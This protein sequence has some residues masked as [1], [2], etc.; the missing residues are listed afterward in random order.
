MKRAKSSP[1]V[2]KAFEYVR[3]KLETKEWLAGQRLPPAR[4][5]AAGA[6][7]SFTSMI[8]AIQLLKAQGFITVIERGHIRAAGSGTSA[9]RTENP[10]AASLNSLKRAAL[11]QDIL[12]GVYA[13]Q[14]HLPTLKELTVRYGVHYRTIRKILL[15]MVADK[16]LQVHGKTFNFIRTPVRTQHQRI[17]F[18]THN[19]QRVPVTAL[20]R[21][22]YRMF[23]LL[24]HECS[25]RGIQLAIMDIEKFISM[26][27]NRSLPIDSQRDSETGFIVDTWWVMGREPESL[28]NDLLSRL[29]VLK[30]PVAIVD[31]FGWFALS[32]PFVMN[33]LFQVFC[34]ERR[35]AGCQVAR[36]LLSTGHRSIVF[37]SSFHDQ[38]WSQERLNGI[39]EQYAKAGCGNGVNRAVGR[40]AF[41]TRD[42]VLAISGFDESLIRKLLPRDTPISEDEQYRSFLELK[43]TFSPRQY[44]TDEINHIRKRLEIIK[45]VCKIEMSDRDFEQIFNV[46]LFQVVEILTPRLT[47]PLFEKALS[48]SQA[49]A[50][51]CVNDDIALLALTFLRKKG[52]KVP[53]GLSVVG[54]DNSPIRSLQERLTSFDFNPHGFIHRILAYIARPARPRGPYRH[55]PLEVEGVVIQRDT[56]APYRK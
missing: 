48:Y 41:V 4:S 10:K 27:F 49:T 19:L 22:Q 28:L 5:L 35:K 1:A 26:R 43:K 37:I 55:R 25:R 54:Y 50:W 15:S 36:F 56:V 34:I 44:T 13:E 20:N 31:E 16:A 12:G 7:V 29:A 30:K 6:G 24:E 11:E 21:G 47:F 32:T 3:T 46:V 2:N 40:Q 39:E 52:I 23:D 17:V 53:L 51:V 38:A 45:E 18:L 42:H 8:R 9:M 33:P 14:N